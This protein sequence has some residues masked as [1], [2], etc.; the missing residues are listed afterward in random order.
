[1]LYIR[2]I[3]NFLKY[4]VHRER[5][6]VIIIN[7]PDVVTNV[8]IKFLFN[9]ELTFKEHIFNNLSA[10][11]QSEND[12]DFVIISRNI[13]SYDIMREKTERNVIILYDWSNVTT[14]VR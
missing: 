5:K 3:T 1:M 12:R 2:Y 10:V 8:C 13:V 11:A 6:D 4:N 7:V 14:C 9:N